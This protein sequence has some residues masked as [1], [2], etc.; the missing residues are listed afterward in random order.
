MEKWG[1]KIGSKKVVAPKRPKRWKRMLALSAATR[2][3]GRAIRA[4]R[5]T[6]RAM[7]MAMARVV[8]VEG[9]GSVDVNGKYA[10]RDPRKVPAGFRLTCEK[11]L[12]DPEQT[13]KELTTGTTPWFESDNDSYIYLNRDGRWWIDD[14]S[15]AGVYIAKHD[16]A[17]ETPPTSGY[18]P[19]SGGE[20]PVP[21]VVTAD[22]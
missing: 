21:Q 16:G 4:T 20:L 12:W 8:V 5:G 19:L 17:S 22:P 18:V 1:R 7:A 2:L 6:R 3:G 14:P 15:G 10:E 9:A 13:W 11:M